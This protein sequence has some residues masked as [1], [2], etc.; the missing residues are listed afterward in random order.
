[1]NPQTEAGLAAAKTMAKTTF[2]GS[3]A[4]E[5]DYPTAPPLQSLEIVPAVLI[6]RFWAALRA[7]IQRLGVG[8]ASPIP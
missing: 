5:V 4:G 2:L 6:D 3:G 8:S 1:M 7:R